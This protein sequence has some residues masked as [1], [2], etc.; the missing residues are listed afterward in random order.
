MMLNKL[1][2][3]K[4]R[5]DKFLSKI[6]KDSQRCM[7]FHTSQLTELYKSNITN[8]SGKKENFIREDILG[9]L[10]NSLA[11][12]HL[13]NAG[14]PYIKS[15]VWSLESK[16]FEIEILAMWAKYLGEEP[17]N[18][19]G[20]V[21]SGSTEGNMACINWHIMYFRSLLLSLENIKTNRLNEKKKKLVKITTDII[22]L[23][24]SDIL[25]KKYFSLNEEIRILK[26]DLR[27]IQS[28]VLYATKQPH[29]HYSIAK[30]ASL[31]KLEKKWVDSNSDGSINLVSFENLIRRHIREIPLSPIILNINIGTTM[32]GAIDNAPM[33]LKIL[34]RYKVH[35]SIHLDAAML[36]AVIKFMP[37]YPG[38]NNYFREL[39]AKTIVV[40]GHKFLGTSQITG[41]A[42]VE[43]RFLSK[44]VEKKD[45]YIGYTGNMHDITISGS[46][47]G[48]NI[49]LLHNI[50]SSLDMDS[51]YKRLKDLVQECLKNLD[52]LYSELVAIIGKNNVIMLPNQFN[53]LFIRPS[54]Y[55]QRKYTLMPILEK[56]SSIVVTAKVNKEK[57]DNF[58]NEYKT[59]DQIISKLSCTR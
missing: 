16:D 14:S 26:E 19:S 54:K 23:D 48:F 53:I 4:N 27:Q 12:S 11:G 32:T 2:K 36:G 22:N 50:M 5:Y 30:I 40:S 21:T 58:L 33:L 6:Q 1:A 41:V 20:Y 29:S 9:I 38:I 46:R 34:K 47:S 7:S 10:P 56:Y 15:S 42:C 49:M 3:R 55:M 45:L 52:Y 17:N 28:P 18:I 44:A 31:Y 39:E 57:I 35:Y 25:Y 59:D 51:N 37:P 24:T 8:K 43:K 13:N